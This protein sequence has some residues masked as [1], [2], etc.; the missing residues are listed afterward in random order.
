MHCQFYLE[1]SSEGFVV[2]D[3]ELTWGVSSVQQG[4]VTYMTLAYCFGI[5]YNAPNTMEFI[6]RYKFH[7]FDFLNYYSIYRYFY[8]YAGCVSD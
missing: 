5:A 8:F 6:Q 7:C 2:V 4:L 1:H 3:Q